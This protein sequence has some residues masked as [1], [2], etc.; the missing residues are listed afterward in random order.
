M[1]N[2]HQ[3]LNVQ[4]IDKIFDDSDSED[5]LFDEQS[6]HYSANSRESSVGKEDQNDNNFQPFISAT[7]IIQNNNQ[8]GCGGHGSICYLFFLKYASTARQQ[9]YN[10]AA[11]KVLILS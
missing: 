5:K 2:C 1:R 10:N 8:G 7:I 4:Q 9:G 11:V 3:H 6:G